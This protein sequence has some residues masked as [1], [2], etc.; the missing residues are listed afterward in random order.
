MQCLPT[1]SFLNSFSSDIYSIYSRFETLSSQPTA[2]PLLGTRRGCG[3]DA[4]VELDLTYQWLYFRF[5]VQHSRLEDELYIRRTSDGEITCDVNLG[6]LTLPLCAIDK[7]GCRW[8]VV[9]NNGFKPTAAQKH[10]VECTLRSIYELCQEQSNPLGFLLSCGY[11]FTE[12]VNT[13]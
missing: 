6:Y 2:I 1:T 12:K 5:Y 4:F 10:K 13:A 9:D 7:Y 11:I 3:G 8:I